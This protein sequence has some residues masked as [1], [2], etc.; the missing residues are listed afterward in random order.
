MSNIYFEIIAFFYILKHPEYMQGFR[1]EFFTEP[2]I[3]NIFNTV[4]DFVGD[5]RTEPTAE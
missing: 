3:N 5:Y 2:T 4:K 1:K